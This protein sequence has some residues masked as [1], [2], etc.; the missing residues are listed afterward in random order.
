MAQ[1][2]YL[3]DLFTLDWL[4]VCWVKLRWLILAGTEQIA[5]PTQHVHHLGSS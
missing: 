2:I 1:F 5:V 3:V 4:I